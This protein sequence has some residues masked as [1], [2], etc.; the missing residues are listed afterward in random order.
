MYRVHKNPGGAGV[1]N[2]QTKKGRFIQLAS[3][4]SSNR[5]WKN[6]FFFVSG[7]W[8]FAPKERV[9][10]P[11]VPCETNMVADLALKEPTL[12]AEEQTWV[13]D[14]TAW[15]RS[16]E[17][18]M[19]SD[20]LA[21]ISRL[22]EFVY[23]VNVSSIPRPV[24][25]ITRQPVDQSP[26]A[27]NTRGATPRK[28]QAQAADKGKLKKVDKGKGKMIEAEKPKKAVLFPLQTGWVFKIHDKELAP[29]TPAVN[30]P[31]R[32]EKKSIEVPPRV[33]RVL[34]LV[35]EEDDLKAGKLAKVASVPT[36]KAPTLRDES[37]VEVIE[38]PL[39]RKRTLKKTADVAA[40]AVFIVA[41]TMANFIANRRK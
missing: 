27:T 10:G 3:K 37:E 39:V 13:N 18:F 6:R 35:D 36:Y 29:L 19:Y 5:W 28:E 25:G 16:H 11:R 2:F 20:W 32:R 31:V 7:Q 24:A 30:H 34:K 38:A 33:A 17:K 21:S 23:D 8:E 22:S 26:P 15:S 14:V 4:Y 1:Y 12:T 41:V 40:K 9:V